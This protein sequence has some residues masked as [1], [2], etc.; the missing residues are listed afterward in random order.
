MKKTLR[1]LMVG[2]LVISAVGAIAL[3]AKARPDRAG[4][5]LTPR[6]DRLAV[7]R[8]L[9]GPDQVALMQRALRRLDLSDQQK[10]QIKGILDANREGF[11]QAKDARAAAIRAFAQAVKAGD[12]A[13]IRTA[14]A[15]S[16]TPLPMW[17]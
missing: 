3:A 13:A 15:A 16:E 5:M 10:Q 8:P 9:D 7:D 2:T 14:G 6:P 1:T 11:S 4:P 17:P 12:E